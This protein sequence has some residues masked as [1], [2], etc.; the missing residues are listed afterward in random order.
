MNNIQLFVLKIV[1]AYDLNKF[2]NCNF[3]KLKTIVSIVM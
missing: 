2:N 1:N 3:N